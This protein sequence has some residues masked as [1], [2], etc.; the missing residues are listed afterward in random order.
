MSWFGTETAIHLSRRRSPGPERFISDHLSLGAPGRE[1]EEKFPREQELYRL[2]KVVLALL[3]L[4]VRNRGGTGVRRWA[5]RVHVFLRIQPLTHRSM[6][7][8]CISV[9]TDSR[10]AA[11]GALRRCS[12]LKTPL[13]NTN[14][15]LQQFG[16]IDAVTASA[17]SDLDRSSHVFPT[18]TRLTMLTHPN[19]RHSS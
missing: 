17:P 15:D 14:I 8:E 13:P 16:C 7:G 5:G 9:E 12:F 19:P 1:H 6:F 10:I 3:H 4:F 11:V 18:P 2:E